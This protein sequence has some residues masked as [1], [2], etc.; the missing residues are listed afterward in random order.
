MTE[1][2]NITIVQ[3]DIVWEDIDSNLAKY[4]EKLNS[5]QSPTDL[6]VLPEMFQTGFSMNPSNLAELM[7]GKTMAWMKEMAS[8][9]GAVLAGSIIITENQKYYNRLL[10]ITPYGDVKFYDKKH[11]F[12]LAGEDKV[13]TAGSEKLIYE[14]NGWK[15]CP[16]ICYD[17]R[18]PVWIRNR[19]DYHLL[20]FVANWPEK[21]VLHW[22]TLLQARAIE[23]QAFVVGVNRV[24]TDGNSCI[25]SGD[26][27]VYDAMGKKL[28]SLMPEKEGI[29]SII[30][31]M[32]ELQNTR[33]N[34]PF[35]H[36]R[37]EFELI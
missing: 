34:L 3:A 21:R 1:N 32:A 2:L 12:T 10:F 25:Y 27:A 17:L 33:K 30:L 14:I 15:I 11:L 28:S 8:L 37:D 36:D 9:K 31:S 23:N 22:K 7:N 6:I 4:S 5:I 16:M 19:E 18:F 20:V 26:S 24:G 29:E 35:S 13:Y